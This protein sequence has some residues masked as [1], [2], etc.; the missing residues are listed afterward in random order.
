MYVGETVVNTVH[1][2]TVLT[3]VSP[4]YIVQYGGKFRSGTTQMSGDNFN[5]KFGPPNKLS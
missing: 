1:E 5:L 4:T 2:S 3:T